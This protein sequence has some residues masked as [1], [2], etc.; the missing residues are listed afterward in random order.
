M[1]QNR[2]SLSLTHFT[3]CVFAA[4]S[5]DGYVTHVPAKRE[6]SLRLLLYRM[7]H[8]GSSTL[9]RLGLDK[10]SAVAFGPKGR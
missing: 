10:L 1:A 6:F 3:E 4:S 8:L 7:L 9:P 5:S 2:S